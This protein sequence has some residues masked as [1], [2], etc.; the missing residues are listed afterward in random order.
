MKKIC[1]VLLGLLAAA[2]SLFSSSP[3]V[4]GVSGLFEIAYPFTLSEGESGFS[5]AF[6]NLDLETGDMD[7]NKFYLGM[8][9]GI[10]ANMELNAN[11]SYHSVKS[12]YP[13]EKNVEYIFAGPWQKGPGYASLALKYNFSKSK[14]TG[15]AAMAYL[16]FRL[17]GEEKGVTASKRSY[18]LELLFGHKFSPGTVFSLN[19]GSR[20]NRYPKGLDLDPGIT[21][22]FSAAVQLAGKLYHGTHLDPENPLEGII[23]LKYENKNK[24]G[25]TTFGISLA[26]KRNLAFNHKSR[27]GSHG[28]VGSLWFYIG[29]EKD[30]CVLTE[31]RI[32]TVIIQGEEEAT[33]GE[34][35]SYNAVVSPGEALTDEFK[36]VLF[37]WRVSANGRISG[38][39][40][41]TILVEWE[42]PSEKSWV[43]VTVS[44]KCTAAK[45]VKTV[46][47]MPPPGKTPKSG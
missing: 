8:G 22:N 28:A 6:H 10:F 4:K 46:V 29:E 36:P 13:A 30:S 25:S 21:G 33:L 43:E 24:Y 18:G 23:G 9:W 31:A 7:V 41:P 34:V 37:V 40:S 42:N 11:L 32:G 2:S 39:G 19:L 17:S 3:D 26:Y 14:N 35:T 27:V 1:I 47:L 44:N 38:Q 45:A 12:R 16:D 5:F 20:F 15:L